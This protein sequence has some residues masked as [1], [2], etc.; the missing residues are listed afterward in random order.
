MQPQ[1][2][3]FAP[4][5]DL[6]AL[7]NLPSTTTQK[8]IEKRYRQI[9]KSIHPDKQ[10]HAQDNPEEL[11][12]LS[13][14]FVEIQKAYGYLSNPLT[15]IIYDEFGVNGLAVY[16]KSKAKFSELQDALR[17]TASQMLI[18]EEDVTEQNVDKHLAFQAKKE[19]LV[20]RRTELKQKIVS[21]TQ[22]L[23]QN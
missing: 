6:Y 12:R 3:D 10:K 18:N 16:E 2:F 21:K 5:T 14:V 4:E 8:D 1:T 19:R 20:A 23:I 13:Q 11:R 15:K 9:S 22:E 17:N 7:F